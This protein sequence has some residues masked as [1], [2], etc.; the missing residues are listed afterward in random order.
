MDASTFSVVNAIQDPIGYSII[1]VHSKDSSTSATCVNSPNC[2][3]YCRTPNPPD[4]VPTKL[5]TNYLQNYES[6][7]D[8]YYNLIDCN[9]EYHC[10]NHCKDQ[11]HC[12][13]DCRST[14]KCQNYIENSP[15]GLLIDLYPAVNCRGSQDCYTECKKVNGCFVDCSSSS[16][17]SCKVL[18]EY[19]PFNAPLTYDSD[20][21][22]YSHFKCRFNTASCEATVKNTDYA[23]ID[24]ANSANCTV[25]IEHSNY[26]EVDCGFTTL[27][28]V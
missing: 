17:G 22:M 14:Q 2:Y 3:I 18:F 23:I 25:R 24:C 4:P 5:C 8:L 7:T 11:L 12:F 9:S 6:S 21:S 27:C 28:D 13:I 15:D 16:S 19:N 10:I 20:T 26:V 1:Y